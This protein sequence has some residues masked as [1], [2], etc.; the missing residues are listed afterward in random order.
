MYFL[1][2]RRAAALLAAAGEGARPP[3][4]EVPRAVDRQ[5]GT[6]ALEGGGAG[7]GG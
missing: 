5:E 3:E 6:P 1:R 2:M 4:R 7:R